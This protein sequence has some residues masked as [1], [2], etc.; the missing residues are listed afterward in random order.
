MSPEILNFEKKSYL[1]NSTMTEEKSEKEPFIYSYENLNQFQKLMLSA[2]MKKSDH[3]EQHVCDWALESDP[4]KCSVCFKSEPKNNA[5]ENVI[6]DLQVVSRTQSLESL[7]MSDNQTK[8]QKLEDQE[9]KEST[10]PE[11][12]ITF[13]HVCT[14]I[15]GTGPIFEKEDEAKKYNQLKYN[16]KHQI[17]P[18][19]IYLD[20]EYAYEEMKNIDICEEKRCHNK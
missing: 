5:E 12:R 15:L 16:G 4:P 9:N 11:K 19:Y 8:K 3:L 20:A 2:T 13:F 1:L 17:F 6:S 7:D 10:V 18:Y 14:S